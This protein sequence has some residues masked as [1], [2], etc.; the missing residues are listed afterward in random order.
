MGNEA[1]LIINPNAGRGKG[2]SVSAMIVHLLGER[3]FNVSCHSAGSSEEAENLVAEALRG[4]ARHLIAAGGD[5]TFHDVAN[6]IMKQTEVPSREVRLSMIPLGTGNDW[7]KMYGIPADMEQVAEVIRDG[8]TR[9]QDVGCVSFLTEGQSRQRYFINIA[10]IGM[11]ARVVYDTNR[12]KARGRGGR[13]AYLI[14]LLQA[15]FSYRSIPVKIEVDGREVF[16]DLLYSA[17]V[18]I[19]RF[20]GGGMQ[21]VPEALPDDGLFDITL[22]RKVSKMKVLINSPRLYDGSFVR[23]KEVSLHRGSKV[24]VNSVP[25]LLLEADGESLGHPPF[26][27]EILR[28]ALCISV[29]LT[30]RPPD[31]DS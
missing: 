27:F 29:P 28:G 24:A 20:S 10:G 30:Y 6:G 11:D 14:S 17:N 4:G 13:A 31:G 22:I 5:G 8:Q 16:N 15:T 19:C 9:L 12:R 25:E 3:G 2:L 26:V 23:M 7:C 21:Q 18:G 1:F